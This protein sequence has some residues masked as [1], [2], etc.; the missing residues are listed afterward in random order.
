MVGDVGVVDLEFDERFIELDQM[1]ADHEA[2]FD[3]PLRKGQAAFDWT[4]VTSDC[5]VLAG[6][7]DDLRIAVWLLRARAESEGLSGW[8]RGLCYVL[9]LLLKDTEAVFPLGDSEFPTNDLH[10]TVLS[11]L[12]GAASI[13]LFRKLPLF[14]NHPWQASVLL[15]GIGASALLPADQ[16]ALDNA[17]QDDAVDPGK[18]QLSVVDMLGKAKQC[19]EDISLRLDEIS[20]D[21]GVDFTD[22]MTMVGHAAQ[23]AGVL[24]KC[25]Q[26]EVMPVLA[27]DEDDNEVVEPRREGNKGRA[28]AGVERG[29]TLRNRE[30]VRIVLEALQRYY[31]ENESGHPA[32]IFIQR[33]QRMVDMNFELLMREL[34]SESEV[35]INRLV[36]PVSN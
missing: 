3:A 11:W 30:D 34:F 26:T 17:L 21:A 28:A 5:E 35:L 33:L 24:A 23:K 13:A 25:S 20:T 14:K 36:R 8:Y 31:A 12:A 29:L 1:I 6:E 27:D 4:R 15:P 19:I 10:V 2:D 7:T 16:S 32:P 18:N 22:L 9:E